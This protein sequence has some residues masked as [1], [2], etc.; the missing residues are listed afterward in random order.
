MGLVTKVIRYLGL[1]LWWLLL[2]QAIASVES[3]N[4]EG[5]RSETVGGDIQPERPKSFQRV[6]RLDSSI[7]SDMRYASDQNFVGRPIAGYLAP[8][9]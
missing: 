6:T 4:L 3:D 7:R 1:L 5:I 8:V 2:P 9:C